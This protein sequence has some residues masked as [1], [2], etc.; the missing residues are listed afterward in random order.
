MTE[1]ALEAVTVD[2]T[3][4]RAA[5]IGSSDAAGIA[6]LS[7]W[8]TPLSVWSRKVGLVPWDQPP[9]L[10]MWLGE[11]LE[12]IILDLYEQRT[13]RR[14]ERVVGAMDPPIIHPR[15]IDEPWPMA[16]HPD[17]EGLEVKT[18]RSGREWGEDGATVTVQDMAVPLHYFLQVQHQIAVMG[19][20]HEDVAV[21]IG[22]DDFRVYT[23]PADPE[24]IANLEAAEAEFR[25]YLVSGVPPPEGD[26][27]ARREYLRA[28][29]PSEAA[30]MR[31][32][33]PE[34]VLLV[35]QWRQAKALAEGLK[36]T[37]ERLQLELA[38]VIGDAS[39]LAGLVTY[40]AQTRKAHVV[41]E[42]TFRVMRETRTEEPE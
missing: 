34:E 3:L 2:A 31:P 5:Y 28:R 10:R 32:A 25:T 18:A 6:N 7:P 41:K 27:A 24:V 22:H 17:F 15:Y 20:D 26:A 40:R 14:P 23:V 35:E 29:W 11:R 12:P 42:S 16:A 8:A 4:D 19:W 9:S 38:T 13:Q 30:G 36:V 1:A 33:T 37:S 39:G 21:L